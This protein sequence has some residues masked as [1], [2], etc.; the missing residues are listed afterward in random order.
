MWAGAMSPHT[1]QGK[2]VGP[3]PRLRPRP[4]FFGVPVCEVC[5]VTELTMGVKVGCK[6]ELDPSELTVEG[7][8]LSIGMP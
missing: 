5:S 4:C 6:G 8:E 3:A 2:R 7:E 1:E